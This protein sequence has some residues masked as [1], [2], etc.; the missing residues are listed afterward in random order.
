M[1]NLKR[2][3]SFIGIGLASLSFGVSPSFASVCLPVNNYAGT[4]HDPY[5]PNFA[6]PSKLAGTVVFS[7]QNGSWS[8]NSTWQ[9]GVIPGP[10]NVV[11]INH[12]VTYD[13]LL[14]NV[15]TI[16]VYAGARLRFRT[17]MS[18][19]LRVV[20]LQVHCSGTLEVGTPQDP[21]LSPNAAEIIFTNATMD[22]ALDP[23]QYG[24]GLIVQGTVKMHGDPLSKSFM[25]VDMCHIKTKIARARQTHDGIGIGAVVIQKPAGS[26]H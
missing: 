21:I 14:G 15:N 3:T 6:D 2:I 11:V 22:T 8:Q 9:G 24:H 17:D 26:M 7:A 12:D 5:L 23:A 10:T 25:R 18:T 4:S 1:K 13:T 19:R 20:T 16:V